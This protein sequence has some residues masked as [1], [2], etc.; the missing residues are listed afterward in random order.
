[1]LKVL[2]LLLAA[3]L[4]P[5]SAA[6]GAGDPGPAAFPLEVVDAL[7][8]PVR[9]AAPP[10]RIVSVAPSVTEILFALGLE[11]RIAGV[12]SSD[13]YPAG[14][15]SK[16]RVG[17]VVLDV[18]R[19]LRLRPDLVVGV[20]SLQG[21]QLERL[22]A[23]RLPVLAVDAGT[24]PGVYA[25][26]ELLGRIAAVPAAAGRVVA[27]MRAREQAV[28][29]AVAGRPARRTYIE[30]WSEPLMT[31]GGGTF[32]SDLITRAGGVNVF[33]DVA[34]WPQV[35]EEAVIRR[36]PEVIVL[37]AR[38]EPRVLARR[39]WSAVAAVRAGRIG[40]VDGS[41]LTRPGPRIVEGLR[42]LAAI[43][44]PEAFR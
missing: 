12:G 35:S 4:P 8:R 36:D 21:G 44:H 42:A 5:L 16:P 25:Q 38:Q 17:G 41:L 31:A 20:A 39:G 10:R 23:V 15:A 43:I 1:M 24:L 2:C 6:H 11:G 22:I 18:E 30:F 27:S 13:D 9:I 14:A 34:G 32:V 33:A 19:I 37:T 28:A 40:A 26:V 7:G 3:F 29:R